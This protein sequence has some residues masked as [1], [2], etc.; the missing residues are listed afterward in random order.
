MSLLIVGYIVAL[1]F[2]YCVFA[3]NPRDEE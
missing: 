2:L 1:T 3:V